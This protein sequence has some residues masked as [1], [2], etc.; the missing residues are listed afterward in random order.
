MKRSDID[1]LPA[2]ARRE[3]LR[4][5]D[6][7]EAKVRK[8]MPAQP[9]KEV[10]RACLQYLEARRIFAW[11]NNTGALATGNRFV[12]FGLQGSAD[13]IGIL[14]E[15]RFLAVECKAAKGKL[16]P[17][18]EAFLARVRQEGGVAI[19]VHNLDELIEGLK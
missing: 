14:P 3:V 4:Q 10:V 1:K 19:V 12:R 9:E 18:Q 8:S 5:L 15:G 7:T 13:I 17:A 2:A 6:A 11:R 16:S